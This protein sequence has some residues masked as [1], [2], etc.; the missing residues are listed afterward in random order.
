[1]SP[2]EGH[3]IGKVPQGLIAQGVSGPCGGSVLVVSDGA[4]P[5]TAPK[6]DAT[7]KAAVTLAFTIWFFGSTMGLARRGRGLILTLVNQRSKNA[8]AAARRV[9]ARA[10]ARARHAPPPPPLPPRRKKDAQTL[11]STDL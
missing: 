11:P 6:L 1:M 5:T 4:C 2:R 8:A 10:R 7:S 9:L 3:A